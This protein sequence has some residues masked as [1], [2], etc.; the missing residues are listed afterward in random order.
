MLATSSLTICQLLIINIPWGSE[1]N[2]RTGISSDR[3]HNLE[4]RRWSILSQ[5]HPIWKLTQFYTMLNMVT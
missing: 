3:W 4:Y 2:V 1:S 5:L